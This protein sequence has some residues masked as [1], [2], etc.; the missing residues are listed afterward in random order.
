MKLLNTR[1]DQYNQRWPKEDKRKLDQNIRYQQIPE[2]TSLDQ[3]KPDQ[4][5]TAFISSTQQNPAQTISDQHITTKIS[6]DLTSIAHTS[7]A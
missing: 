4:T 2:D 5:R 1:I 3:L 6:S 7:Q